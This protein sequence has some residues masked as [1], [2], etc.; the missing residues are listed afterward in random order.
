MR[1]YFLQDKNYILYGAQLDLREELLS[2]FIS[3]A[4]QY[5]LAVH[6]PLGLMDSTASA[7]SA[8]R[9]GE[10]SDYYNFYEDM[11]AIYRYRHGSNQLEFL[12]D[13][14]DHFTKYSMEWKECFRKWILALFAHDHFLKTVLQMSVF[15]LEGHSKNLAQ[16]RM[17]SYISTHFDVKFYK[18]KGLVELAA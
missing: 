1:K 3:E 2:L 8:H 5:Y 7:I 12:F 18:Y 14:M 11:C 4:K 15:G 9:G 10:L 13:G 17:H 6:N 16:G